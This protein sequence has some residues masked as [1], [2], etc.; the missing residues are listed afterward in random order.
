M[1]QA[2]LTYKEVEMIRT[3]DSKE[4]APYVGV[5]GFDERVF[6]ALP[7]DKCDKEE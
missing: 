1:A 3:S 5:L 2:L 7:R 4:E 6:D